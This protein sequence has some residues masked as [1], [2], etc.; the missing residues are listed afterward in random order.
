MSCS[1]TTSSDAGE[2]RTRDP[3]VSG[4]RL[5]GVTELIHFSHEECFYLCIQSRP[6]EGISFLRKYLFAGIK[7]EKGY[8]AADQGV[9]LTMF[10]I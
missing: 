2:A 9:V 5:T 6:D 4:S 7:N 3:S 1:R 10:E 8:K